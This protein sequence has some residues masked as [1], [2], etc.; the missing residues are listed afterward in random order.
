LRT[1][2]Y[3][4][5]ES[6]VAA[7]RALTERGER[8][9]AADGGDDERL[10]DTLAALDV[11]GVLGAGPDVLE[12]I[13]RIIA[14]PGISPRN[15]VLREAEAR[16]IPIL[17]EVGLGLELLGD[18]VRVVAVTGTNGKTTVIDML[19]SMLQAAGVPHAVAGNSWRT[20]TGCLEEARAAGLLVLE[21][22]SFQLHY[23]Q[24]PGFEVAALLNVRPDHLNWHES[25]EE[26]IDD[27]LRIFRRQQ[28]EDLAI[29]SSRD[30]IGRAAIDTLRA[31][32]LVV[33]EGGTALRDGRLLLYDSHLADVSELRFAGTHNHENALY[34]AAA[35]QRLGAALREIREALLVYESKPH[36]MRVAAKISG[37]TYVDDS[38][39]T[40]P[41]A[42]AAAL[43]SLDAPVVLILGGSEKGTDF[44]EVLP[45]LGACRAVVCQGEAGPR[46]AA[47][48]ED[49]GFQDLV[50]S[51]P[52]LE[53]AVER[54]REL[55]R[56]GDVVLL[57]PG[58][59][60]FDQFPGYAERG[61]AFSAF[62]RDFAGHSGTVGR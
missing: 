12:G 33:G 46:I 62:A 10:R 9:L 49:E 23:L 50:H 57:S 55:A 38:K 34:A 36:R 42:V 15:P 1:L 21:V 20:I 54:A 11:S 17:S 53:K 43:A 37:V 8:V 5:G 7:T 56:P 51:T 13:D 28:A 22:S 41:A 27:K 60:S 2:V 35:A 52:D 14:S 59:A 19:H 44:S 32:V 24:S 25:F 47:Y 58:C 3:G 29:V 4:L 18:Y 40:N 30:P 48:L 6:G 39:A 45:G 61:D 31:E 26:Y 16:G